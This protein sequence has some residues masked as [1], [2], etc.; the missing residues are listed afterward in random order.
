MV[1]FKIHGNTY[2][3]H[4]HPCTVMWVL[5]I[6]MVGGGSVSR[7]GAERRLEPE[8]RPQDPGQVQGEVL[9]N[10]SDA[11]QVGHLELQPAEGKNQGG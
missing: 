10:L 3:L 7:K 9:G 11:C 2:R 1:I 6:H 8:S 5:R 4:P